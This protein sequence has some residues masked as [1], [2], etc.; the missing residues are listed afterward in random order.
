MFD[1]TTPLAI[2][3]SLTYSY[4]STSVL[5]ARR[6]RDRIREVQLDSGLYHP[7]TIL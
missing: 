3:L 5:S 1:R 6:F 2:S 4:R 7:K